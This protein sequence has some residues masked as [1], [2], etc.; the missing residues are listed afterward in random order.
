MRGTDGRIRIWRREIEAIDGR[1]DLLI[2]SVLGRP[3]M[4]LID[5]DAAYIDALYGYSVSKAALDLAT[6]SSTAAP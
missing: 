5:D 4:M 2:K 6:A 3:L 1:Y